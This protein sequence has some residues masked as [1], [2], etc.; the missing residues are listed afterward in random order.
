MF[1]VADQ[2]GNNA[3]FALSLLSF[4]FAVAR[5]TIHSYC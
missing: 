5:W 4:S 3:I 2:V 1:T